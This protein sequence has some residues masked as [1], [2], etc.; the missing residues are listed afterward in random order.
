MLKTAIQRS[1]RLA[2]LA[3][4]PLLLTLMASLHAWRGGSL[5]EKREELYADAVDLLLDWWESPKIVRDAGGQM[6]VRHASLAE[7]LKVDREKMRELLNEL[8]YRAQATQP[9]LVGTADV[10]EGDLVSGL[11]R[12]S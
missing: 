10:P 12:L 7:W 8:A 2:E 9:D 1:E 11:M 4:R 5:P 3:T 6:L